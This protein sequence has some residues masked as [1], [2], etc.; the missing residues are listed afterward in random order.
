MYNTHKMDIVFDDLL[1]IY[2][3][4]TTKN[5]IFSTKNMDTLIT[6]ISSN[7]LLSFHKGDYEI[8]IGGVDSLTIRRK[9]EKR[10]LQSLVNLGGDNNNT[11]SSMKS[12]GSIDKT[13]LLC[14]KLSILMNSR[15][16][17][18][19][20]LKVMN[21][22]DSSKKG[23]HRVPQYITGSV[24]NTI[25]ET[26]C[27]IFKELVDQ[28]HERVRF[29]IHDSTRALSGTNDSGFDNIIDIKTSPQTI[30]NA[31]ISNLSVD[32]YY[33]DE[34]IDSRLCGVVSDKRRFFMRS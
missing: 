34:E 1:L 12:D 9:W 29:F 14:H 21:H 33:R 10:D 17:I 25:I 6:K 7:C 28:K 18:K 15:G 8:Y 32:F 30:L 4:H 26:F 22:S 19:I 20:T 31:L 2:K 11:F 13:K 5:G 23:V 3:D 16:G 27:P 24:V